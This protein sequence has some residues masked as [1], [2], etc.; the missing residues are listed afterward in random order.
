MSKSAV[1]PFGFAGTIGI[2]PTMGGR[3]L[4]VN[5]QDQPLFQITKLVSVGY[6]LFG[7]YTMIQSCNL[8]I[9]V[10]N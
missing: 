2:W 3:A 7:N 4:Q 8:G 1:I 10:W 6:C 5:E 9:S